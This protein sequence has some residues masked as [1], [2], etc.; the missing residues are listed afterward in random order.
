MSEIQR[1][2]WIGDDFMDKDCKVSW[3]L[4]LAQNK[5]HAYFGKFWC[6]WIHGKN[7]RTASVM[8]AKGKYKDIL[9]LEGRN[10]HFLRHCRAGCW[11]VCDVPQQRCQKDHSGEFTDYH[12]A[13]F[14]KYL[15]AKEYATLCKL[16]IIRRNINVRHENVLLS[17]L[18]VWTWI[19]NQGLKNTTVSA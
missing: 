16:L 15:E 11:Y 3:T 13:W 10:G 14:F 2:L 5:R 8:T 4:S 18:M 12:Y 6:S 9:Q 7:S 1:P 19:I 17:H